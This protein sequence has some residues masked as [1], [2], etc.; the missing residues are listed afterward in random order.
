MNAVKNYKV[1]SNDKEVPIGLLMD[2]RTAKYWVLYLKQKLYQRDLN[3]NNYDAGEVTFDNYDQ[4]QMEAFVNK[5]I[6]PA[7]L[8][9]NYVATAG[10][11][12]DQ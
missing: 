7:D 9:A 2:I 1:G 8:E 3:F 12:T 5:I 6:N 4:F 11:L 10:V